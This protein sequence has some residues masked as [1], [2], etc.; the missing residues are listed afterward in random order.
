VD[1]TALNYDKE[2]CQ[3]KADWLYDTIARLQIAIDRTNLT[4]MIKVE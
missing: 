2:E 4:N 1:Y 3:A